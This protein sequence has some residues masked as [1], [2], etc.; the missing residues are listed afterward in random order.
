[1]KDQHATELADSGYLI[2]RIVNPK[3]ESGRTSC[4]KH[5]AATLEAR[6]DETKL[7]VRDSSTTT[8]TKRRVA[9]NEIAVH[10]VADNGKGCRVHA[11]N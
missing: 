5:R 4:I 6:V 9:P 1:M 10:S 3:Q 2:E 7:P 11:G 8:I